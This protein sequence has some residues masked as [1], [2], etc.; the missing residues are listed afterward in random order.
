MPEGIEPEDLTLEEAVVL[1]DERV[2]KKPDKKAK[3][4]KSSVKKAKKKAVPKKKAGPKKKDV[5]EASAEETPN[6]T[7]ST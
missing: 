1:L 3:P 5:A 2:A 6:S 7:S 4:K